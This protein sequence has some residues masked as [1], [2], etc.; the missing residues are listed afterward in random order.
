[1][2]HVEILESILGDVLNKRGFIHPKIEVKPIPTSGS[3]YTSALYSITVKDKEELKLFAKIA[4]VGDKMREIMNAE[5]LFSTE[6]LVYDK[7]TK[8]FAELEVKNNVRE[9]ETFRFPEF[10]GCNPKIGE[11]T[12][13]LEDLVAKGYQ[14]YSRFQSIDWEHASSAVTSLAKYHA[15]SF[16]YQKDDPEEF[17]ALANKLSYKSRNENDE[18]LQKAYKKIIE[19]A[20]FVIEDVEHKEV[21]KKF[22]YIK[23]VTTDF[24]K[25]K[26]PLS[27][28]VLAH[29]DY[30]ASNMM[31]KKVREIEAV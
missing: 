4:I 1:M 5:T 30:R 27:A 15:L 14:D 28:V 21:M 25:F 8:I 23:N 2:D 11:E 20:L 19:T 26:R 10:F 29:G 31:F 7:L 9:D 6:Q 18:E 24:L 16:A 22:M 13:I 17:E 12:V 3:N